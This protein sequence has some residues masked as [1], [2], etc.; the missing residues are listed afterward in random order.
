MTTEEV[1]KP[2]FENLEPDVLNFLDYREFLSAWTKWKK[3]KNANF[4]GALFAKKGGF[5]SHTLLGM[6][7]SSRRNL[8]LSGLSNFIKALGLTGKRGR[9]FE[10]LVYYNQTDN[11]QEKETH[12]KELVQLNQQND[13]QTELKTISDFATYLSAWYYVAVRELVNLADFNPDPRWIAKKLKHVITAKQAEK[14]WQTLLE[15][16]LIRFDEQLNKYVVDNALQIDPRKV[17][18]VTRNF[19]KQF[20]DL[21]R[22]N[23]DE[24]PAGT[25]GLSTLTIALTEDEIDYVKEQFTDF[26]RTLHMHLNKNPKEK[27]CLMAISTQLVVLTERASV[28]PILTPNPE[29]QKIEIDEK[30][31]R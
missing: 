24:D 7:T 23:I 5:S 20:L 22:R 8:G 29:V 6:V 19:H 9:Y 25:R 18:F 14:A 17:D 15:L 27:T 4:S 2:T 30:E 1:V 21:A 10:K 28:A 3:S 31:I 13:Q 26:R 11:A 16:E 12:F